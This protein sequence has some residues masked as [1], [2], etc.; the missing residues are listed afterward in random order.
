LPLP[1]EEEQQPVANAGQLEAVW[2]SEVHFKENLAFDPADAK[3]CHYSLSRSDVIEPAQDD[4][5]ILHLKVEVEWTRQDDAKELPFELGL[6]ISGAF[7]WPTPPDPDYAH[8]WLEFNGVYL[9]WPYLRSHISS[10]TNASR[11]PA[12][13]IFTLTVPRPRAIQ[14]T[15]QMK[16]DATPRGE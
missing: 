1:P 7:A 12:L 6:Q 3:E 11:L 10:I 8:G 14:P 9:L 15:D 2:L 4:M 5:W 16:L 13:T